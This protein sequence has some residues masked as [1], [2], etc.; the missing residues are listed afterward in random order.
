MKYVYQARTD[1]GDL[2][3]DEVTAESV[4]AAIAQIEAKGWV[5]ESISVVGQANVD[6]ERAAT[7]TADRSQV[8]R[9]GPSTGSQLDD[10]YQ[11]ALDRRSTLVPALEALTAEMPMGKAKAEIH[12]L[13]KSLQQ[14]EFAA[15]L[16]R[17][18]VATRWLPLLVTGLGDE[19]NSRRV[20]DLIA[21]ASMESSNR[22][23]RRRAL[24]YPLLLLFLSIGVFLMLCAV[25]VPTFDSMFEEFGLHLPMLTECIVFVSRQMTKNPVLVVVFLGSVIAAIYVALRVWSYFA[26]TTK[27]FGFAIAGN[28]ANVT[29]MSSLIRQLAELLSINVALPDALWIAGHQCQHRHFRHAAEQLARDAHRGGINDSLAAHN[30]PANVIHALQAGPGNGPHIPLLRELSEMYSHRVENRVDWSTGAIAQLAMLALGI[31]IALFTIALFAPLVSLVSG[32]S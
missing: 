4:T 19:Q 24:A 18:K 15:D 22:Q 10:Q 31:I 30:F 9:S 28:S 27:V 5:V 14:A 21:H 12:S 26:L 29:A 16:R 13:A 1:A 32:L 17:S 20:S 25:V 11:A 2:I 23:Q 6:Q 7:V 8:E 3:E